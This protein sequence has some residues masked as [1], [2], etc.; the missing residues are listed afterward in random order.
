MQ[1]K[2]A[3]E[4]MRQVEQVHPLVD[5]LTAAR[6]AGIRP[7][8]AVISGSAAVAVAR[9]QVHQ[10]TV[11]AG[12]DLCRELGERGVE[13]VVE[14][15]LGPPARRGGRLLQPFDLRHADSGRLLN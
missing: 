5:Q 9:A 6:A 4:P 13:T 12:V 2:R 3:S 8:L 1:R 10:V 15:D 11:G 7:P 14:P